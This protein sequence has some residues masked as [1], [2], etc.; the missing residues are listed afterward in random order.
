VPH[1]ETAQFPEDPTLAID[2]GGD[3]MDV[4]RT[5][6]RAIEEHLAPGGAAVLQLGTAEQAR[7]VEDIAGGLTVGEVRVFERGVLLRLDA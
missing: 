6:T 2:G 7:L 3:G 1:D 5:C 4:V